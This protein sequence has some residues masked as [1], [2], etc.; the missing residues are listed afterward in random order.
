M[1][2]FAFCAELKEIAFGAGLEQIGMQ[3]FAGCAS[4]TK[5]TVPGGDGV[6]IGDRAFDQ[7]PEE[8]EIVY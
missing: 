6:V 7:C 4:L 8:I 2:G 5:V 3:A 1:A